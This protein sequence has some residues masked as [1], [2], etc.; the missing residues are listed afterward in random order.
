[1][2][3]GQVGELLGQ[4]AVPTVFCI[5]LA[6]YI[7]YKDDKHT[8]ETDKLNAM[9]KEEINKFADAL[10]DN[11]EALNRNTIVIEKLLTKIGE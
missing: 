6:W 4:Y 1:M 11:A 2:D 8:V 3:F 10:K 5:I 7:K 9:H